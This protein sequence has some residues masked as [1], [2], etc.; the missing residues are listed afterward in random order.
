MNCVCNMPDTLPSRLTPRVRA[1]STL[2]GEVVSETE[3]ELGYLYTSVEGRSRD[4]VQVLV[5][6]WKRATLEIKMPNLTPGL[7]GTHVA[8]PL[9]PPL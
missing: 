1:N 9:A 4:G 3:L 6:V 2:K 5:K 7:D 8:R